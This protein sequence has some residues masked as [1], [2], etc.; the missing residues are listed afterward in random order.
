MNPADYLANNHNLKP[1]KISALATGF[2]INGYRVEL[3]DGQTIVL[4]ASATAVAD[5]FYR[6]AEMLTTLKAA[7]W[8]TP[9]VLGRDAHGLIITWLKSDNSQL[10]RE[11]EYKTGALL[12]RL[13]QTPHPFFGFHRETPIGR[14]TQPN[15]NEESW[16]EFFKQ[17]RLLYMAEKA[18]S[19]NRLPAPL[20]QRLQNF[21]QKLAD[22]IGEPAHPSLIHGDIWGGNVITHQGKLSG[23]IDPAIYYA[24]AEIELAFTQMFSTFGPEFFNGYRS[25][26]TIEPGFFEERLE[27]Y[28]LYPTLV[29]VR[30]FGAGYLAPIDQTLKRFG[31]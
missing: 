26:R 29:H 24:H 7:G 23:F 9:D 22:F 30:L 10:K 8:P 14:L 2:G 6:E 28:N 25:V 16:L 15:S 4:K 3:E 13:H 11:E 1:N 18:H 31:F 19:E 21:S 5:E 27:I 12:A 17:H 20:Y